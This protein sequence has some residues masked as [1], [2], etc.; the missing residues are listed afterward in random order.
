M[1]R[2]KFITLLG[3]V[4]AWPL[5]ARAQQPGKVPAI[6]LLGAAASSVWRPW[7][8]A[9]VQRLGELGWIEGRTITIEYRWA[10]GRPE[11]FAEIA[12]EFVRRNVDV[13]V[14]AES[15]VA[16]VKQATSTIPIIIALGPDPIAAGLVESLSRPGGNITGL[17]N[18]Q[19]DL[20]G[21]RLELLREVVP[22]LR[23]LA[24]LANVGH[25]TSMLEMDEVHCGA[26]A[27][28]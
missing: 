28:H 2:R 27:R 11:R 21:K 10:E 15:A 12:A 24:I 1:R 17:S 16:A 6:G 14:T 7:T 26:Q 3:G 13:I 25:Q 22:N 20:A 4:A 8:D 18:V 19:I 5:A 9:F 23:R